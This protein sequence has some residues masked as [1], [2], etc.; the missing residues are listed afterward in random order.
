MIKETQG[1]LEG[2]PRKVL[3]AVATIA[4]TV[5]CILAALGYKNTVQTLER[6]EYKMDATKMTVDSLRV[7]V[8]TGALTDSILIRQVLSIDDRTRAFEDRLRRLEN[9]R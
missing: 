5:A 6:L 7:D 2:L 4:V 3:L 9:E 8:R 1:I